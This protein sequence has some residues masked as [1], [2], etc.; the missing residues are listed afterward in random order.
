MH[1]LPSDIDTVIIGA[2]PSGLACAIQC[3]KNNKPFLLIEK[4]NRVGGRL[5]SFNENGYIY[6]LGFQVYNTAYEVTNSLLDMGSINLNYFKP[7]AVIH[8]GIDFQIISD[9]L[10][11]IKQVFGT[12]FS[13]IS[14]L[15]DKIRILKLKSSLRGYEINQ[16]N[17]KDKTTHEFLLDIGFSERMIE[18]F[19]RPF[20]AGIFL[21]N[22]LETSSKFFKYVFSRFNSGLAS[23][24][25]NGMQSI[26]DNLLKNIDGKNILLEKK[27]V[28]IGEQKD[29][30]FEDGKKLHANN[31]VLTGVSRG[32]VNKPIGQYNAT[33]T[34]Y[35]SSR[36]YPERQEYIHLY[37]CDDLINNIAIPTGISSS[38]S[39]NGDHLFSVTVLKDKISEN[40]LIDGVM[41]RLKD[42]YGGDKGDYEFLRS[43]DIKKGTLRQLPGYFDYQTTQN[44][45]TI[46]TGEH[47]T[48]GSIEGAIIS[49]IEAA[50]SL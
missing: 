23:L 31:I 43:I 20:F 11:D 15:G 12:L 10:R 25:E 49:G 26:P 47:Q 33:K 4:N 32:L 34:L 30:V 19:F 13:D 24:P 5:G 38:Y 39:Q 28:K 6:D 2:G 42:Y 9:P 1:E 18:M 7:G 46:I 8:D 35:I 22:K 17:S 37:P 40:D 50:D 27:V 45:D 41:K 48:N 36:I 21:E 3:Q 14:T 29:I 44:G 16:D